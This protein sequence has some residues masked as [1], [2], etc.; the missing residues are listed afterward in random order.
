METHEQK[1]KNKKPKNKDD[2]LYNTRV[3]RN[4][5]TGCLFS[6]L[7]SSSLLSLS[8]VIYIITHSVYN[9]IISIYSESSFCFLHN[10]RKAAYSSS[11]MPLCSQSYCTSSVLLLGRFVNNTGSSFNVSCLAISKPGASN[12]SIFSTQ[13]A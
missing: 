7:A 13:R 3:T 4:S 5:S 11:E 9:L 12:S 2:S 6:L 8:L 1:T 10:G